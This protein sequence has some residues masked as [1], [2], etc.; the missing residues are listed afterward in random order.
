LAPGQKSIILEEVL[1]EGENLDVLLLDFRDGY[2]EWAVALN[3][4]RRAKFGDTVVNLLREDMRR[5]DVATQAAE[6]WNS[7]E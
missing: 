6:L 4:I 7:L 1:K 3:P 5:T 2:Q